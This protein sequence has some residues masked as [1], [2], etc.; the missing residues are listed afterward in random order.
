[1]TSQPVI[2]DLEAE[3]PG[4]PCGACAEPLTR[5]DFVDQGLPQPHEEEAAQ[6]YAL[7]TGVASPAHGDCQMGCVPGSASC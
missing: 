7:R 1:M 4:F 3:L 5:Q 2:V 6:P